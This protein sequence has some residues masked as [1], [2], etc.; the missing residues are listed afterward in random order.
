MNNED[1]TINCSVFQVQES[2]IKDITLKLNKAKG[3]ADKAVFAEELLDE[4]NA[5]LACQD[6][7][8]TS[9]DCENCRYIASLRKKTA[10]II[11]M[12]KRLAVN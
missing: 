1:V 6:Y 7:E 3:F 12:A 9:A 11:L 2:I 5:L 10:D 8:D 4:V